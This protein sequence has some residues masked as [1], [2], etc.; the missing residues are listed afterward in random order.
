M[1]NKIKDP[2]NGTLSSA[3][4]VDNKEFKELQLF[5][6]NKSKAKSSKQQI[7]IELFALQIK[8]EDY[9]NSEGDR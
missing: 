4:N 1:K 7:A 2:V 5:L 9:L 3:M 6:H 8:M